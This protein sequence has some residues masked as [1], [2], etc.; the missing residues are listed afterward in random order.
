MKINKQSDDIP[1][2]IPASFYIDPDELAARL[3]K[4]AKSEVGVYYVIRYPR[5]WKLYPLQE[6]LFGDVTHIEGWR[7]FI[8]SELA[9][10]WATT[11]N[12]DSGQLTQQLMPYHLSFPRGRIERVAINEFTIFQGD[13]LSSSMGV[14]RNT[15]EQA[16][17]IM[18]ANW[19]LDPHEKCRT[20]HKDAIRHIL[21]ISEDWSSI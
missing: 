10:A 20:D 14:S 6:G 16:F 13:D 3:K 11:L 17:G 21:S 9:D 1:I 4:R 2:D 5:G 12:A 18:N 19:T 8:A 7:R 15:I